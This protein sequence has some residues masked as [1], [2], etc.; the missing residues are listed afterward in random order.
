MLYIVLFNIIYINY[1]LYQLYISSIHFYIGASMG[2]GFTAVKLTA[3]GR[4]QL[5][6]NKFS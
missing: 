4:P 5:L 2:V 1:Q 6:V 3:L